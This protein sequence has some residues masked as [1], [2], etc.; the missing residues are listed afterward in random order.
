VSGKYSGTLG[1]NGEIAGEW[2]QGQRTVPL[3]FK[4]AAAPAAN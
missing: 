2:S 4:R 3:T 1:A